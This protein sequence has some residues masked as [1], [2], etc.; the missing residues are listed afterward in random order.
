VRAVIEE[1]GTPEQL[2]RL[3]KIK[4]GVIPSPARAPV[5]HAV[6]QSEALC[7]LAEMVAEIK[8]AQKPRPRGRPRKDAA[9]QTR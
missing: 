5:E 8:E 4:G 1:Y 3:D 2:E 9:Q 7:V 6:Y